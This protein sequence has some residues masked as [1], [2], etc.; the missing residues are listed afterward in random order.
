M[1]NQIQ[2]T[3]YQIDGNPL[4]SPIQVAFLTS[5]I[6]I[7]DL[8]INPPLDEVSASIT[9]YPNTSNQLQE[10]VFYVGEFLD[11]LVAAANVNGTSQIPATILNINGDP[12][13]PG[14][15]ILSFPANSVSIWDT[16]DLNDN[17]ITTLQFKNK[18]Y[19]TA[20]SI[21]TLVAEANA[22]G[23]GGS[24]TVTSVN[25]VL[26]VN[27]NVDLG[28][29]GTVTSVNG[30]AP[31]NGNV[32]LY[33]KRL[34]VTLYY[35]LAEDNLVILRTHQNDGVDIASISKNSNGNY[36]VFFTASLNWNFTVTQVFK[37][38]NFI[39]TLDSIEF[40]YSNITGNNFQSGSIFTLRG[41]N[42]ID[43]IGQYF[44]L[45]ITEIPS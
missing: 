45:E 8:T 14:G 29:I 7:R 34:S 3:V 42:A 41:G 21:A 33:S 38:I 32:Q 31:I 44:A 16:V 2:A 43:I 28:T 10:Q 5:D 27:G 26:P 11:D 6:L 18:K 17:T 15:I 25:E 4:A 30:V 20:E 39:D 24:G 23:G 1:A 12:Q 36:T 9:Y 37:T 40:D 19:T 13:T 35:S 22:G